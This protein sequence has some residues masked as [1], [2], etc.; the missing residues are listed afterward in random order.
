MPQPMQVELGSTAGSCVMWSPTLMQ[1]LRHASR[2]GL[3]GM[4]CV[5]SIRVD[6][7]GQ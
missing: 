2:Q 4:F 1:C 5:H 7:R 6:S 3:Q